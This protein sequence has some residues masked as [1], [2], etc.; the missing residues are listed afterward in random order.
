[1][2]I[3]STDS[4][5]LTTPL[6]R[7][8]VMKVLFAAMFLVTAAFEAWLKRPSSTSMTVSEAP[9]CVG[10][11]VTVTILAPDTVGANTLQSV[12]WQVSYNGSILSNAELSDY[13]TLE[14]ATGS[15]LEDWSMSTELA[16]EVL[17]AGCYEVSLEGN[18]LGGGHKQ[19]Q[20]SYPGANRHPD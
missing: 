12:P 7:S 6:T 5:N 3:H 8:S 18:A 20:L 1:M 2:D 19:P 9:F 11:D 14:E 16:F 17:Q 15:A 4:N 13:I 10:D